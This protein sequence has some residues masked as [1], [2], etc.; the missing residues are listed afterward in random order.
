MVSADGSVVPGPIVISNPGAANH[1]RYQVPSI[2]MSEPL[3]LKVNW[4]LQYGIEQ[5]AILDDATNLDDIPIV[6]DS[7]GNKVNSNNSIYWG[8]EGQSYFIGAERVFNA[9]NGGWEM[10]SISDRLDM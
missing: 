3:T 2:T 10:A 8:D 6:I 1:G 7:Q 9:S 4:G 5:Q